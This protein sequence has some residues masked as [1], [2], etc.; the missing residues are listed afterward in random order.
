MPAGP[1]HACACSRRPPHT[2][3]T[4]SLPPWQAYIGLGY[5]LCCLV[6]GLLS[7]EFRKAQPGLFNLL[8]GGWRW[9]HG[10][11]VQERG[12]HAMCIPAA[13]TACQHGARSHLGQRDRAMLA[14]QLL[15]AKQPMLGMHML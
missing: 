10:N 2:A 13:A 6:G 3:A 15:L 8:F 14:V 5:S 12:M 11:A 7:P 4:H 9:A 1:P